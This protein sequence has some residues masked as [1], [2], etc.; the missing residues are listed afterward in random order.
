S[1]TGAPLAG[2]TVK[3]HRINYGAMSDLGGKFKIGYVPIGEWWLDV[4]MVGYATKSIGY[5]TVREHKTTKVKV[6]LGTKRKQAGTIRL[7]GE[8]EE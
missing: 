2:A 7:N 5:V 3:V 6:K 4:T 1:I 8:G